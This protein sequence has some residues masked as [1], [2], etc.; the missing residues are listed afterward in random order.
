MAEGD[1]DDGEQRDDEDAEEDGGAAF[2]EDVSERG[3]GAGALEI[4]PSGGEIGGEADADAEQG[5][6]DHAEDGVTGEDV[7]GD[8][9]GADHAGRGS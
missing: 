7:L 3:H 1:A 6:A 9:D 2:G 5:R 8:G 4:E